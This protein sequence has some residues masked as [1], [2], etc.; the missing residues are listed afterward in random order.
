M[1]DWFHVTMRITVL[2]QQ[3]MGV[4]PEGPAEAGSAAKRLESIKHLLW[5]GN[6]LEA[7]E[8]LGSLFL[9]FDMLRE[10][11]AVAAK[12]ANGLAD[13]QTYIKN[14]EA[15]KTNF[16]DRWRQGEIISTGVLASTINQVVSRRFVKKQQMQWTL[17][18]AH[19]LLQTRT[20]VLNNELEETFRQW[21]PGFRA[22]AA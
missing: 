19:L 10:H 6:A 21:N 20:K 17:C 5:H 18:G 9:K 14:N 22:Q 7:L 13:F 1:L 3:V 16:G 4:C 2:Q 12:V 8:R 11:S 15:F